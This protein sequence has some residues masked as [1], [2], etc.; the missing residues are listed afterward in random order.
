MKF[1]PSEESVLVSAGFDKVLSLMDVRSQGT[2]MTHTLTAEVESIQWDKHDTNK[3]WVSQEDGMVGQ[4]DARKF[5][6]DKTVSWQAG[7]EKAVTSVSSNQTVPGLV[8]TTSLDMQ[9]KVW[10]VRNPDNIQLVDKLKPKAV[11]Y[12][13][14]I[15]R[16]NSTV[17][18]S[19][20]T[21]RCS[22]QP[23]ERYLKSYS[24]TWSKIKRL[25][26]NLNYDIGGY[27][28][29]NIKI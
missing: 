26:K 24:G 12:S 17:A 19:I 22:S 27:L 6:M 25:R 9:I 10:D 15:F 20:K 13:H 16:E 28:N 4:I 21:S 14:L 11:S 18:L 2:K 5:S 23:E 8:V 3:L 29:Y 1:N 7:A